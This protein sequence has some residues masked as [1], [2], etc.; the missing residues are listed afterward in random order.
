MPPRMRTP[1]EKRRDKQ[2]IIDA[3]L[4][5]VQKDGLNGLT[6]RK[7]SAQLNMSSANIYNYFYNKE[8]IYLHILITGFQ[9]L[10]EELEEELKSLVDPIERLDRSLRCVVGF[11][12]HHESYYKLMF[13]TQDPKPM[14]YIGTPIEELAQYEKKV[15]MRPFYELE[16]LIL[17]C[18]SKLEGKRLH[19]TTI[20]VFSKIHGGINLYQSNIIR[21]TDIEPIEFLDCM[22]EDILLEFRQ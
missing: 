11:A 14:D 9:I 8:E 6:T 3:A 21:E 12:V 10:Q 1:E 22:I 7:L 20:R 18:D 19:L 16:N 17:A 15:A 5:I 2:K 4:L 13:S